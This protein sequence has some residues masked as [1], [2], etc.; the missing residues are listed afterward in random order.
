MDNNLNP[1]GGTVDRAALFAVVVCCALTACAS[2]SPQTPAGVGA[3]VADSGD[4]RERLICRRETPTG[5]HFPRLVCLTQAQRDDLAAA[6]Q[7]EINKTRSSS[8]PME[9]AR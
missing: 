4:D 7:N 5:T 9:G 3:A 1:K 6:N 2:P 8:M